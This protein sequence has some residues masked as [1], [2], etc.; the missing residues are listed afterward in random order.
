MRADAYL[1]TLDD[2]Q[3]EPVT[4]PHRRGDLIILATVFA[5][6]TFEVNQH[7]GQAT[8]LRGTQRGSTSNPKIEPGLITIRL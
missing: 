8:H 1:Q 2:E 3:L 6:L 7:G 5:M 4:I